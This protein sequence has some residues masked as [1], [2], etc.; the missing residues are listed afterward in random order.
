MSGLHNVSNR[1]TLTK[2]PLNLPDEA[3]LNINGKLPT[4]KEA[5]NIATHCPS[6]RSSG[7]AD[8]A[9]ALQIRLLER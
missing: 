8:P 4:R 1:V 2:T 3:D 7:I 9:F 6:S 5:P